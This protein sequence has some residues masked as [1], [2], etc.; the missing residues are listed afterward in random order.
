MPTNTQASGEELL[1][2]SNQR[3]RELMDE[4]VVEKGVS[5]VICC[6][7]SETRLPETLRHIACQEVSVHLPWEVIVVDNASTD[8]TAEVA[9]LVWR[10]LGCPTPFRLVNEPSPGLS[11][12][13][14]SG[15]A[16]T[17]YQL[18]VLCDDDNWLDKGYVQTAYRIMD[19][20]PGVGALGGYG[21]AVCEQQ[22]PAWFDACQAH[23]ALGRQHSR[24]G[25]LTN[26]KGYVYGAGMVVNKRAWLEVVGRGY[27]S[28]LSDR[29]GE[30][31]S[32]GGDIELCYA[33]RML[34]YEIYYHEQLSFKHFIPASRLQWSYLEGLFSGFVK[35]DVFLESWRY[36]V[37]DEFPTERSVRRGCRLL[38]WETLA[39]IT[40]RK[41]S[42][43]RFVAFG[44]QEGRVDAL[45]TKYYFSRLRRLLFQRRKLIR[46]LT[47]TLTFRQKNRTIQ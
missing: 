16:A 38:C 9:R 45:Y 30:L 1:R 27:R 39:K 33:F 11:N 4:L 25:N 20:N 41:R 36:F 8:R 44:I 15:F 14:A 29:K 10:Q 22:A 35:A 13:R 7:N 37:A 26:H 2:P 5:V 21:Q 40:H 42:I 43:V 18:M 32:S 28:W 17:R 3:C 24:S 34:G 47:A 12:A 31:L 23:Y 6:Y 46:S 19:E